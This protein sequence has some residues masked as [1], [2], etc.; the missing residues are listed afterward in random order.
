MLERRLQFL[1]IVRLITIHHFLLVVG[2]FLSNVRLALA[3]VMLVN[4][5]VHPHTF[6]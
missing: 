5:D 3:L 2:I 4:S 6:H 1:R